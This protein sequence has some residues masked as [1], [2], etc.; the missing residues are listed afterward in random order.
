[1]LL[2]SRWCNFEL[3]VLNFGKRKSIW[4]TPGILMEPGNNKIDHICFLLDAADGYGV[5][6]WFLSTEAYVGPLVSDLEQYK[7][8][9]VDPSLVKSS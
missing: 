1:M 8:V 5:E 2:M 7:V 4:V 3:N 9:S 6:A